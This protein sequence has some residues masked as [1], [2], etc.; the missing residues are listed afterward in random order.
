MAASSRDCGYFSAVFCEYSGLY[1]YGYPASTI[2][3]LRGSVP[4]RRGRFCYGSTRGY[5]RKRPSRPRCRCHGALFMG[6]LLCGRVTRYSSTTAVVCLAVGLAVEVCILAAIAGQPELV[7]A[8]PVWQ[9]GTLQY[10]A[11]QL[12]FDSWK[13]IALFF[14]KVI[15][16]GQ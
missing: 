13:I 7:A 16:H 3:P 5:V 2:R 14:A 4:C 1:E 12:S 6:C 10:K 15:R 8:S 11:A 9:L